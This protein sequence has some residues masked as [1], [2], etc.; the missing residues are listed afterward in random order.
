MA[1]A[2]AIEFLKKTTQELIDFEPTLIQLV[3]APILVAN[4]RGGLT[5][6]GSVT[7]EPVAKNRF[8]SQTTSKESVV[9]KSEGREIL[10]DWVLVGLVDDDIREGD[11]FTVS[12][13][14]YKVWTIH[15][16]KRWQ[17]KGLV[18]RA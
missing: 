5:P 4:G 15:D 3:H 14:T 6:S 16:D 7:P 17:T 8:F 9:V 1:N 13:V 11:T 2:T 18:A 12:G 10:V